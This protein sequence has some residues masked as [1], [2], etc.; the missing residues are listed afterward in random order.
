MQ[1][2]E[3]KLLR[4][5]R[6][7]LRRPFVKISP[8]TPLVYLPPVP[9]HLLPLS[10]QICAYLKFRAPLAGSAPGVSHPPALMNAESYFQLC[11]GWGGPRG[12]GRT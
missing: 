8:L 9:N 4:N 3:K 2:P 7:W 6:I 5:L 11:S 12:E 1:A 10:N